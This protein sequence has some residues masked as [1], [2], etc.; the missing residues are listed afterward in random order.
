MSSPWFSIS[1]REHPTCRLVCF[2]HAGGSSAVYSAWVESLPEDIEVLSVNLPGRGARIGEAS[3][4]DLSALVKELAT[5]LEAF[6][7]LPLFFFGHSFGSVVA[8]EVAK[9]V[10]PKAV[11]VSS[12]TAPGTHVAT[13]TAMLPDA[14]FLE[15]LQSWG[16]LPSELLQDMELQKAVLPGLRADMAMFESYAPLNDQ[17][18]DVPIWAFGGVDDK[19]VPEEAMKAWGE[20]TTGEF[21]LQ[22][23][24][25]DHFYLLQESLSPL[26]DAVGA[27]IMTTVE[28][29]PK[30]MWSGPF[31][32][33]PE[34]VLHQIY[35][36]AEQYPDRKI[37]L[38]TV[39]SLT[40]EEL[41]HKTELLA[42]ALPT[43]GDI[44]IWMPH[45]VDF[46]IAMFA[47]WRVG[48]ACIPLEHNFTSN[49]ISEICK[50][51]AA[52]LITVSKWVD[53]LP[54]DL[55]PTGD[56]T[57]EPSQVLSTSALPL[58]A[59]EPNWWSSAEAFGVTCGPINITPEQKACYTFTS[60][61]TGKPK[62]IIVD[63]AGFARG[64][65]SRH[66]SVP[67]T[68]EEIEA[69]NVMFA[70]EIWR[71]LIAGHVGLVI[72]DEKIVDA[73][74]L[75]KLLFE[76]K[77]T[78]LLTTP[79]MLK[80][81]LTVPV[82]PQA[83]WAVHTWYLCGEVVSAKVVADAQALMP[84]VR[85]INMYSTWESL[86]ISC[87]DLSNCKSLGSD[88]AA[89]CGQLLDNVEAAI[90]HPVRRTPVPQGAV[91]E[92]L[93]AGPQ[94][95]LGYNDEAVTKEKFP[96]WEGKKWY[97][98]GDLARV[99][100]GGIL[101]VQ[102][103]ADFTVKIRG[104]KVGIQFVERAIEQIEGVGMV[105]VVPVQNPATKQP[106][107]LC[108]FV[109]PVNG[110]FEAL[111][112]KI[113]ADLPKAVPRWAVPAHVLP[114][115]EEA[116]VSSGEARKLNRRALPAKTT[117]DFEAAKPKAGQGDATETSGSRLRQILTSVWC[118]FL[119][120]DARTV[121]PADSFFDLGGHSLM[122][123]QIVGALASEYGMKL[124]V[125]DLYQNS[126]L[127]EL[128]AFFE[129]DAPAPTIQL[130][131][132][133]DKALSG[134][135]AFIGM[136]GK[137][138]GADDVVA[139]W[140]NLKDGKASAT[141]LTREQL[142]AKGVE[143][144]VYNNAEFVKAGYVV[145]DPDMFDAK[146]WGFGRHESTLMDP[147]QRLF[148]EV[149]WQALES[150]GYPPQ[151]GVRD[152][153]G[154]YAACG[155]DG[156][157]IHHL[158]G[159]PLKDAMQPGD[160]FLGEV[161]NEKDY[162]ST[163]VSY[164]LNLQG[165]SLTINSA[166]SSGLV[167]VAQAAQGILAGACDMAIAGASS[168]TFP[169]LGF[170][171]QE[172]LVNSKDG[173]VRP[174]DEAASG[175]V[176][177]DAVGAVVLKRLED[178]EDDGDYIWGVCRGFGT[179]NDGN[180]KA[181]FAAPA[182]KGQAA[183][184]KAA[185]TMAQVKP[186][187][188][189]Y[190][191]CHATGTLIGDGLEIMGLKSLFKGAEGSVALGS[192][193]GNIAHANCAAGITGL[194]KLLL[195]MKHQKMVPT[196][197]YKQLNSKIDLSETPF[198]VNEELCEWQASAPRV[199]GVSSFGIG[200]TNCHMV[201]Q[202][203]PVIERST[204]EAS[205]HV[206][207]VSAKSAW[208]LSATVEALAAHL[209]EGWKDYP[210]DLTL[211]DVA[212]TLQQGREAFPVRT[213]FV[214]REGPNGFS[215]AAAAMRERAPQLAETPSSSPQSVAMMFSGQ[216]SQYL[217]MGKGL[218]E[219]VPFFRQH[220]DAVCDQLAHADLLGHDI[221]PVLF[222]AGP[223]ANKEF[224]R[225]SVMQPSVF[226][227][228]YALGRLLLEVGLKPVAVSGHSLGEYAAATLAGMLTLEGALKIVALRAKS[229]EELVQEGSMLSVQM[230]EEEA[231]S[232]ADNESLWYAC[233]NSQVHHVI[234]GKT[235]AVIALET[236]LKADGKKASKLHVTKAFHSGLMRPAAEKLLGITG[237]EDEKTRFPVTANQTGGWMSH[238]LLSLGSYW[239]DHMLGT[240]NWT[241][242]AQT[243]YERW[244]PNIMLEVGPGSTLCSLTGK[245]LGGTEKPPAF[246]TTMRHPKADADDVQ[247]LM[248]SLCSL[249][250][251]GV[252]LD[253]AA[254]NRVFG[255]GGRRVP[256]PTYQFEKKSFWTNPAAS[257]YVEGAPVKKAPV[258]K[259]PAESV[260]LVRSD[261]KRGT[262]MTLYCLPFAG[263][264]S[265][266]FDGWQNAAVDVVPIELPGRGARIE[267]PMPQDDEDDRVLLGEIADA[268]KADSQGKP[269]GL[270]GFSMGGNLAV[271]LAIGELAECQSSGQLLSVYI[272][273]RAPPQNP[274]ETLDLNP[275]SLKQYVVK[276]DF[277][278]EAWEQFF[279]PMLKSDLCLDKRVEVRLAKTEK[280]QFAC[281]LAIGCGSN[282]PIFP[283]ASAPQ[284][285]QFLFGS[286]AETG[287]FG[288]NVPVWFYPGGHDFMTNHNEALMNQIRGDFSNKVLQQK[289]AE[290][291]SIQMRMGGYAMPMF[292]P[293][294]MPGM[295]MPG[296]HAM[297]GM[298]MPGLAIPGMSAPHGM[299]PLA[300]SA[301]MNSIASLDNKPKDPIYAV[302]WI[303]PAT[304]NQFQEM[305]S[306]Q[307]AYLHESK[308]WPKPSADG[309][310]VLVAGTQMFQD[311]D[312]M[313]P[314]QQRECW[315]FFQAVQSW[316]ETGASGKV[317]IVSPAS[318]GGALV[319]GAS[320][321]IALECPDFQITR[322]FLSKTAFE[323]Q[324]EFVSTA[325]RV[326]LGYPQESDLDS[327]PRQN[328]GRAKAETISATRRFL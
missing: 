63:H 130:R 121:D 156:Y 216:G 99:T 325:V 200:G 57:G 311:A 160:I 165:P 283:Y 29:L 246:V 84:K 124:S 300:T 113:R 7:Q 208:S 203:P 190:V 132:R 76:Y 37:L 272:V 327:K 271:E 85:F 98:T 324:D 258:K 62:M 228:E 211:A 74:A 96:V 56:Q 147:Q 89:P 158:N 183:A 316:L 305:P 263:G 25:G 45:D 87:M 273:G 59:L 302:R 88:Q 239:Q 108:A 68:G 112:A 309:V 136:A 114:L 312:E 185:M 205:W 20:V 255:T 126:S 157:L 128:V 267:E 317:V 106:E 264:S 49:M 227:V 69:C 280:P 78:R 36:M 72:P 152:L 144:E 247:T 274:P 39:Q 319:V 322:V 110:S 184:V 323:D 217:S 213:T 24:P 241:K 48:A 66:S 310:V 153:C 219:Q 235:E 163:R 306:V 314:L 257:V 268:I 12:H 251:K 318:I 328:T 111:E 47:C 170:M 125:L 193:K 167:A 52:G 151:T 133:K 231:R 159:E 44:A 277:S 196:A 92:L 171:W 60:G 192:V 191:E 173:F 244:A 294:A 21:K 23:F 188:Y 27:S 297:P 2:P 326:A 149:S 178:A 321:A 22:F 43:T 65:S 3:I 41:I 259:A 253:W 104:F 32:E 224:M 197:F 234:A 135:L 320:K 270:V 109:Q 299:K 8:F 94:L 218:Y 212:K 243:L 195:M 115:P 33:C 220:L 230:S 100:P 51:H 58:I 293:Q 172:G 122:A 107:A 81:V 214:V 254:M 232:L 206:L 10:A 116:L 17:V 141:F 269:F 176:F 226:A 117:D 291:S 46:V 42:S 73:S 225:P 40:Y 50:E 105:A 80:T 201:V 143:P 146:F 95:S 194:I 315:N 222:G 303:K 199:A 177:G 138:P 262:I 75:V 248:E 266:L 187:D 229:T 252:S 134:N 90:V 296:M 71:P 284:W 119:N 82:L 148:L 204:T 265:R 164:L 202:E 161:G 233:S 145:K 179:T 168:L 221:R 34:L 11:F 123:S 129:D 154:V 15:A 288:N 67:Y 307:V 5:A 38:D 30:S 142:R 207:P 276:P 304:P 35:D 4:S 54:K 28:S 308:S 169:N 103:R 281:A 155:I 260:C 182:P 97:K 93:I 181:G 275:D 1:Q 223:D 301:S 77:V 6:S 31:D 86:D 55:K 120:Q 285:E 70:W 53:R 261:E 180:Q 14:E 127:N 16:F 101:E 137:F 209:E 61:T 79:S 131:Q 19:Q 237:A 250:D 287:S 162:I 150:A 242:N 279:L 83:V 249:W 215:E 26:L 295:P 282:D 286:K 298:Q 189:S 278:G 292:M 139:F 102:G 18:L 166:C 198:Y 240:V 140:D 210:V 13:S 9:H 245:I 91:G 256:L 118:K 238:E 175:T 186:E 313:I 64:M 236:K 289:M 290:L 174:F